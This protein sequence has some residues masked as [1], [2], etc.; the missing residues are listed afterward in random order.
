M[1]LKHTQRLL[2]VAA[3]ALSLSAMP[4]MVFSAGKDGP[5]P[6]NTIKLLE[7]IDGNYCM[8]PSAGPLGGFYKYFNSLYGFVV[9]TAAGIAILWGIAGGAS[10]IL[11][12]GDQGKYEE[13]K[14][15]LINAMIGLLIV[16]FSAVIL[17]FLNPNAFV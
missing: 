12:A 16:I 17:N 11:N 14:Q 2:A 6:P 10:M 3:L 5:C 13:G 1:T 15:W 4:A 8:T 7:P 9:G